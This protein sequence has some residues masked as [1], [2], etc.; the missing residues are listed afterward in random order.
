[1]SRR[2]SI[3]GRLERLEGHVRPDNGAE[4]REEHFRR[5]V[6]ILDELTDYVPLKDRDDLDRLIEESVPRALSAY[7]L[8]RGEVEEEAPAYVEAFKTMFCDL[9]AEEGGGHT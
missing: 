5:C 9:D 3:H 8:S 1:M 4:A 6:A 2:G 7:G